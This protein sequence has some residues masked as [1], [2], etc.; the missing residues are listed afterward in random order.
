MTHDSG[1]M[2]KIVVLFTG[3]GRILKERRLLKSLGT[4]NN[5]RFWL[6]RMR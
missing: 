2:I 6:R 4:G 5:L 1:N 3:I